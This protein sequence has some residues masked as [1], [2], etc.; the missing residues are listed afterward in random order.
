[1]PNLTTR[2]RPNLE[3]TSCADSATSVQFLGIRGSAEKRMRISNETVN[4]TERAK[5]K[6]EG[7]GRVT[8]GGRYFIYKGKILSVS[9]A[10]SKHGVN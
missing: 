4:K 3:R 10:E 9:L 1:M 6:R 8:Q 5:L 7:T 2:L